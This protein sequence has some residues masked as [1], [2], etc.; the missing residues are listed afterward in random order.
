MATRVHHKKE[1]LG[2]QSLKKPKAQVTLLKKY[3]DGEHLDNTLP[4]RI[5]DADLNVEL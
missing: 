1:Y 2:N 3:A 4:S 5:D